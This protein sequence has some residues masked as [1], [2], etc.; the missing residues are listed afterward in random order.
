ME[1]LLH[2]M[3]SLDLF[4]KKSLDLSF[5]KSKLSFRTTYRTTYYLG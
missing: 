5:T 3:F 1:N 2:F 4:E